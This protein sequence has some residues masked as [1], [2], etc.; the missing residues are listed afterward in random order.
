M[1]AIMTARLGMTILLAL[2]LPTQARDQD[3]KAPADKDK[4]V[5]EWIKDLD[6]KDADTRT[7]AVDALAKLGPKATSAAPALIRLLKDQEKE[8]RAVAAWTL[9]KIDPPA[10]E[11]IPAL[12]KSL[13]DKD[14][15]VRGNAITSLGR[16]GRGDKA[17]LAAIS[18]RALEDNDSDIRMTSLDVL[19]DFGPAALPSLAKALKD[20]GIRHR[21]EASLRRIEREIGP[22]DAALVPELVRL[23][24]PED[25]VGHALAKTALKRIGAKAVPA[26]TDLLREQDTDLRC[27]A[28]RI[29][30]EIGADAKPALPSLNKL[31]KEKE[32]KVV[33]EAAKALLTI[34]PAGAKAVIPVLIE[35]LKSTDVDTALAA[36][37]LLRSHGRDARA[38]MP[39]LNKMLASKEKRERVVAATA[40]LGIG[41]DE[42]K[43]ALPVLIELLKDEQLKH[44]ARKALGYTSSEEV[45]LFPLRVRLLFASGDRHAREVVELMRM[46]YT[47][48]STVGSALVPALQ[49]LQKDKDPAVRA[50]SARFL[51]D[52]SAKSEKP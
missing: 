17:A 8:V 31:L 41:E 46:V 39:V 51:K 36:A 44:L 2:P 28:A 48:K 43:R 1:R 24:A 49:I 29:L 27:S 42:V 23:L 20:V 15:D 14:V 6:S 13:Q 22:A 33:L 47:R 18:Q 10:K 26:L 9:G 16:I 25:G 4:T 3:A 32:P 21:A 5:K 11:A 52:L 50:W 37:V 7:R 35:P 38:A 30:G 34:D 40:L 12:I 19:G 45:S